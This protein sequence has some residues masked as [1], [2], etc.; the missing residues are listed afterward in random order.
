MHSKIIIYNYVYKRY[1]ILTVAVSLTDESTSERV[2]DQKASG[3]IP[4]IL[5][6]FA[7]LGHSIAE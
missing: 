7:N 3:R 5:E 4:H 6:R 2:D 1:G